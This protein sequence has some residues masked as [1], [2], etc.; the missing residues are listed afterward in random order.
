MKSCRSPKGCA[1]EHP[2]SPH[3]Q[4]L[5]YPSVLL[6]A[7]VDTHEEKRAITTHLKFFDTLRGTSSS[8]MMYAVL[9]DFLNVN[10][11]IESQ[12]T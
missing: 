6:R 1:Y 7:Y 10:L 9:R 2:P 4:N 11:I 3:P 5:K 12:P 8:T